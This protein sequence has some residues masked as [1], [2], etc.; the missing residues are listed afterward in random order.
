MRVRISIM[1]VFLLA[2]PAVSTAQIPRVL[3]YQGVL[4][5]SLG[6]P[7]ADGTYTFTFRLY[8][9]PSG[10]TA[11]WTEQKTLLVNRGLFH[12]NLGDQVLFGSALTFAQPYWL[13]IQVASETELAPRILL[14]SAGY[15]LASTRSDSSRYAARSDTARYSTR[16][17]SSRFAARSDTARYSTRSDT[18]GYVLNSVPFVLPYAGTAS[19][20]SDA[21]S[22]TQTGIGAGL[23]ISLTST[24]SSARGIN[25]LHSGTGPGIFASSTGGNAVW[26]ITSSISAAGVIGDNTRGEAIV[27]RN[28]GGNGVGAVVGR[29]DSSG[30]G[31]RGFN[32][33]NGIGVFGQAGISG[34]TGVAGKFENVNTNNDADALQVTTNGGGRAALFVSGANTGVS[35]FAATQV[36]NIKSVGEAVWIR[37]ALAANTSPVLKLHQHPSSNASFIDGRTWDGSGAASRQFHITSAGT[38]VA[39]SDFAEA[40]EAYGT[41]AE[42][43]PGDVVVMCEN[44]SKAVEKATREYDSR[45]VGVYSTRPGV[46]G[47]DKNGVTQVDESD[48][49]VAIVGIVP[50]KVTNE[51]GTIHPGDLLTTSSVPGY[52]MKAFPNVVNGVNIYPAGTI[53]GKALEPLNEGKGVI[54][55]LLM[56]R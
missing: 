39:G 2:M 24:S 37:N 54:K 45:V 3:S 41:K 7:K 53:V 6:N 9:T 23:N 18:A 36:E 21:L 30:Y 55:I 50:T 27:G 34:G 1:T 28:R 52:A 16:S 33:R 25:V 31:V 48:I 44:D 22:I 49:P 5:D 17:D 29:N 8:A 46:L 13:S 11:L 40:F 32:T 42:Y 43:E 20:N 56:L 35:T 26:G 15:S 10:G 14:T 4:A 19:T 38:F 47:A 51:N 12:T